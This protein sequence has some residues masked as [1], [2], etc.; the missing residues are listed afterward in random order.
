MII[1]GHAHSGGE[2]FA[3]ESLVRKL[4][5]LGVDKVLLSPGPVNASAVWPIPDLTPV[6]KER[7]LN[8]AGNKLIQAA[9]KLVPER[10]SLQAGNAH[11][12]LLAGRA[13]GRVL[14]SHWVDTSSED[15][16]QDCERFY[17][18]AP[19]AALKLHLAFQRFSL[20]SPGMSRLAEFAATRRLPVFVHIYDGGDA[21]ALL[22]L[23]REHRCAVFIIGH[24]LGLDVFERERPAVPENVFFD[25][26]P[27]NLLP[28]PFVLRALRSF[29][30]GRL[31]LGSDTPYGL[32][33]LKKAVERVRALPISAS[34][35]ELIL[36]RNLA[37]L[38][39]LNR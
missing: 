39:W 35:Q 10:F 18:A 4:D 37:D 28:L 5:E 21:E 7:R 32:D 31:V 36:G 16:A 9:A 3:P 11:V 22:K 20:G 25:I 24:L 33:N 38:L 15:F 29:G 34:D 23:A 26:S 13:P 27:P 6:L 17:D 14:R 30:A 8:Y 19:F 1:D 2:F 12:S